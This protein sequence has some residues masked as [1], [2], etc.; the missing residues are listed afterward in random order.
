VL[1][2]ASVP[3]MQ[4]GWG[5]QRRLLMQGR[6]PVKGNQG[7]GTE[8]GMCSALLSVAC[9]SR[10][11]SIGPWLAFNAVVFLPQA[12]FALL[13]AG[14]AAR[15]S[16]QRHS[17]CAHH[18]AGA[19][20]GGSIRVRCVSLSLHVALPKLSICSPHIAHPAPPLP[21]CATLY[22]HPT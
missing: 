14:G 9:V 4:Q 12:A 6:L 18:I 16:R 8:V 3:G 19:L 10:H 5:R 7:L 13:P 22:S 17:V 2:H 1:S 11:D 20:L 21:I 15:H